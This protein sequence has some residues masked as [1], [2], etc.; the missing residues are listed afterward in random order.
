MRRVFWR[1]RVAS[2][3]VWRRRRLPGRLELTGA[4]HRGLPDW[5]RRCDLGGSAACRPAIHRHSRPVLRSGDCRESAR[6][7]PWRSRRFRRHR[8]RPDRYSVRERFRS[9]ARWAHH[10]SCPVRHR[11]SR[12]LL[13][14]PPVRQRLGSRRADTLRPR[15]RAVCRG[16]HRP[17]LL[18]L[19]GWFALRPLFSTFGLTAAADIMSWLLL[20]SVVAGYGLLA[21]FLYRTGYATARMTALLPVPAIAVTAAY[22]VLVWALVPDHHVPDAVLSLVL[23]AFVPGAAW[24]L[25]ITTLPIIASRGRAAQV[26]A[27]RWHLVVIAYSEAVLVLSGFQLVSVLGIA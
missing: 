20:G 7:G 16:S 15:S 13:D 22:V 23:F 1:P 10:G 12:L 14:E 25:A 18:Y 24:Y 4:R 8:R 11:V 6:T 2:S 3:G 5:R 9:L 19:I 27:E 17:L 26:L 21:S